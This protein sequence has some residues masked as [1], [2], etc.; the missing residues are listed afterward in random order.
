MPASTSKVKFIASE[1]DG[2]PV[3]RRQ[4]QHACL[5]CRKRKKRCIHGANAPDVDT[6][7]VDPSESPQIQP[8]PGSQSQQEDIQF[9][10]HT[11]EDGHSPLPTAAA[12][13]TR[14]PLPQGQP[15]LEPESHLGQQ[16]Q[17]QQALQSPPASLS[18]N[19]DASQERDENVLASTFVGD[20][21]PES[22]FIHAANESAEP[23]SL[24]RTRS[25]L[26]I[27]TR[28][29]SFR[30][31]RPPHQPGHFALSSQHATIVQES[32][33]VI[34]PP[35]EYEHLYRVYTERI[36]PILPI[37][38]E[39]DLF[40]IRDP[41]ASLSAR[42]TLF[43]QTISLAASLDLSSRPHL[44]LAP[45][46]TASSLLLQPRDFH[47]RLASAVF[48][49]INADVFTDRI[50][51]IR[52]LLLLFLFYQPRHA[53]E[54]DTCPLLFSQAVH[55][56]QTLGIHLRGFAKEAGGVD[57]REAETLF[58]LLWALDG[59]SAAFNGR[60]AI[61]HERD[62]DF[63]VDAC[64]ERQ[65]KRPA[66]RL[67]LRLAHKLQQVICLYR[68]HAEGLASVDMPVY[69]SMI[70]DAGAGRAASTLLATL[71]V[72]YH[73]ITILSCRKSPKVTHRGLSHAHLPDPDANARRS[74]SADRIIDSVVAAIS[75]QQTSDGICLLP[76]VPYGLALSLSVNY[77]K[78]R[79]SK[80]PMYRSRA[81][82]RFR[83]IVG[84]LQTL[85]EVYASASFNAELGTAILQELDKTAKG[86]ASSN[87]VSMQSKSQEHA[88]GNGDLEKE[89]RRTRDTMPADEGHRLAATA[90]DVA[91][92]T[93]G[94]STDMYVDL[95]MHLDPE[96]DLNA[97][98]AALGA[99]LEMGL[100]QTWA[101]QWPGL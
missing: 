96:F 39:P 20:M 34:P 54:R 97:V 5:S 64:I 51:R 36:H 61:M 52:V 2:R 37:V 60:P 72:F 12:Q 62:T 4:V 73:A 30:N 45:T 19:L 55:Y 57:G 86:L 70:L 10:S 76:F 42:L 98:D 50:D 88:N 32:L 31:T 56:S 43:K 63:D 14:S 65:A 71:E 48:T 22:I 21:A 100:P 8:R 41:G 78:M 15:R 92:S 46:S 25:G 28:R 90:C 81:K 1:A 53:S 7:T 83:E 38:T 69:E 40:A 11:T 87:G 26:G 80:I 82:D 16:R 66:F 33:A 67:F 85:G 3:K 101:M 47:H 84:L 58:L 18:T 93:K 91:V 75:P 24:G 99:N 35:A 49:S 6:S 23:P 95:F 89:D 29:S 79:S 77:L 9:H 44:R 74:L 94:I 13:S 59:I 68:P 17:Q 27:W